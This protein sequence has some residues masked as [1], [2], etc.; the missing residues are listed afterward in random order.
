M[1]I[2]I[3]HIFILF[4]IIAAGYQSFAQAN[5]SL[6]QKQKITPAPLRDKKGT[7]KRLEAARDRFITKQL[8]LTDEESTKFW[9]IYRQYQQ[10]LTA[11]NV[12]KRLNNSSA[13]ANGTEQI[14]KEIYYESQQVAIRKRYKDAFLKILPPEKVSELYKSE[15]EF[16]DELIK[17]LSER[18]ERAGN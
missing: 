9:P 8:N 13:A 17:Q 5:N 1:R 16:R 15:R 6:V 3:R 2:L 4:F 14:D 12:L 18:S 7:G 10:E 11:V